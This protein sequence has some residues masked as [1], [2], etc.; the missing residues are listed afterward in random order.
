MFQIKVSRLVTLLFIFSICSLSVLA[1]TPQA[2]PY[3]WPRSHDYDVQHYRIKLS[4]DW[5]KK[6]VFGDTTITLKPFHRDLKEIEV[7][8]GQMIIS[9]VKLASG[10][11]LKYRYED[12]ETL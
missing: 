2:P 9:S 5:A 11:A 10:L 4:F 7:D 8:A 1:Q 12:N 3:Q 6:E